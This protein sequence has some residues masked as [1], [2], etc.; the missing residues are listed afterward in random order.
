MNM[1][2]RV[3][4]LGLFILL[5][6]LLHAATNH[7]KAFRSFW[8]PTFHGKRLDYCTLDGKLCGKE[9]ADQYCQML[10]YGYSSQNI[11]APNVGLTNFL[12]SRAQCRGWRCNGFML[13]DCAQDL[14]PTPSQAYHYQ[15]KQ[16][17]YPRYSDYRVDW[18]YNEHN[19][20]GKWAA[21]SFCS[22]MGYMQAKNF[23]KETKI[24][25]TKTI[26]SQELCFGSDCEA[27]KWIICSR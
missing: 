9:V 3:I 14:I 16:F 22:R 20:C 25:A 18:C 4:V 12:A 2:S 1:S 19:H 5:S 10:G 15:E 11:I 17:F 13:I 23:V 6:H 27:F 8:H 21:D 26:G 7:Y 24:G